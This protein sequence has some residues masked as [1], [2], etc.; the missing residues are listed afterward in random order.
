[1][2]AQLHSPVAESA[3]STVDPDTHACGADGGELIARYQSDVI[4]L[5]EPLYRQAM[6]MTRNHADAEDLVQDTLMKAYAGLHTFQQDNNL[7]GWLFRIMT[8]AFI[9]GYRK[10]R[11]RPA[12]CVG[13][14]TDAL[15]VAAA[16]HSA[17]VPRSAEEEML[18][19][20]GDIEI[21]DAMRAL[22]DQF[23]SAVYYSDVEGLSTKEIADL[24]QTPVG[25]VTSR[26]HRG[27]RL[28][29][30]FLTD[31]VDQPTSA[32]VNEAA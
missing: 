11:R 23:R 18:N 3:R 28:L 6:R 25:T 17:T 8:N 21:Q 22:P 15:L 32:T 7:R 2:T 14:I 9:N 4:P 12:H 29:R 30:R 27:R 19:R 1:M 24:M 10:Q 16:H 20:L 26:L 5:R 31:V 13:L